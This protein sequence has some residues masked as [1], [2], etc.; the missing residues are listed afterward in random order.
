[1]GDEE[2]T[3]WEPT[4]LGEIATWG[5]GGTPKRSEPSY[6]KDGNIPWVKTGDLND[7]IVDKV[8]EY[9]TQEGLNKSSAKIFPKGS[10]CM[11]MYGATIG[12]TGILG[13]DAATNQACAVAIVDP[14]VDSQ[15]LWYFLKASKRK[16]I[17][18]GKGGA[19]P[20]I[21]QTVIKNFPFLKPSPEEQKRIVAKLDQFMSRQAKIEGALL[22]LPGLLRDFRESVLRKAVTGALTEEWRKNYKFDTEALLSELKE[23]HNAAGGHRRGNTAIP[24]IDVHNSSFMD[25]PDSWRRIQVREI[26]EPDS[27]ITYGIVK[28]GPEIK[29][30]MPYLKVTSYPRNKI[31]FEKLRHTTPEIASE[32]NR[33]SVRAGDVILS[34]R[35]TVG[36]SVV[37]P[38]ELDGAN[39]AR[40]SA[41]IRPQEKYSS[42]FLRYVFLS[43]PCQHTMR[44]LTKG[45]AV[46]GINIGDV[47]F[48]VAPLPPYEEQVEI[49]RRIEVLFAF[50]D[51]IEE[52]M[53]GLKEQVDDL[54][55][56]VLG[57]AFRGE[58]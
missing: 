54:P 23:S 34:I 37:I 5:S 22:R 43:E 50:A 20:N 19:Q 35:G 33:S 12:R 56:A 41:R 44:L 29:G 3:K 47:S 7:E 58:L 46:Q 55:H 36:R 40:E 24:N 18:I 26:C 15:Y 8:S 48:L 57:R 51:R 52:R 39:I 30:G 21:S 45:V 4:T 28:A 11:A 31:A 2:D 32:Y 9:I 38:E 1:M 27:P 13:M 17:S 25:I 14:S 16:F 42:E 49:V 53:E 6:Y 10:I